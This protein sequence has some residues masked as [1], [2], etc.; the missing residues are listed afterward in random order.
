M[1]A[2]DRVSPAAVLAHLAP[3]FFDSLTA[4]EALVLAHAWNVWLRPE[5]HI[6]GGA[7]RYYGFICGR[8]YG[9]SIAIACYINAQ[10]EAGLAMNIGLMAP[11]EERSDA[12]QIQPLIDAAPPWFKPERYK[13]GLLWP[14]GA[15][16]HVFTPEAP[17][18]PRGPSFD[19]SWLSEIVAW[20]HTT[21]LLA[22]NN[23]TTATRSGLKQV[24]WDTT[25][26]GKNE[27][28]Q[29]LLELNAEDPDR[30]RIQRGEM[31]DNPLLDAA[32]L[33]GECR[34][35]VRG[36]RAFNEEVRGRVYTESAGALWHQDW[37][38]DN[39]RPLAPSSPVLRLVSLDPAI[40]LED[41]ADDTGMVIVSADGAGDFYLEE[42]KSG[43][44][45]PE[46]WAEDAIKACATGGCAGIVIERNRGAEVNISLLRVHAEKKG[47]RLE[48]LEKDKPFKRTPGV[49]YVREMWAASSKQSRAAAPASLSKDG[50]VHHVGPKER[51]AKLELQLT[52]WEPGTRESPNGLDAYAYGI[53]EL[54]GLNIERPVDSASDIRTAAEVHRL[55]R[56]NLRGRERR[57]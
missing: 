53:A 37:I 49:V 25:S 9:K 23:I 28:I 42:D 46:Q 16:A 3:E 38:S 19:L 51:Y 32:Y 10:V 26:K 6:E 57:I 17:D 8:G 4:K 22:F 35:Y 24:L 7:W 29:L 14:N 20:Q 33:R 54:A 12:I 34:K 5:Q 18:G 11:T 41:G 31:F 13:G 45:A 30:N 55:L 48:K 56:Q 44:L 52:T 43:H 50:R 15:R 1:T 2:A 36:T 40:S 27:V 39:R 47:M 21:R